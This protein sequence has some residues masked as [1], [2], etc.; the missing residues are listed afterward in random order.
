[1][2]GMVDPLLLECAAVGPSNGLAAGFLH[3]PGLPGWVS[4][5]HRG[6]VGLAWSPRDLR[7]RNGSR[8]S[9]NIQRLRQLRSS[10]TPIISDHAVQSPRGKGLGPSF[11]CN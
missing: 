4:A 1:M 6:E 11:I 3:S 2:D 5:L 7:I 9:R 10:K 8:M